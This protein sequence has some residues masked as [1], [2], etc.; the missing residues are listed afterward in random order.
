MRA[1]G[2]ILA[3]LAVASCNA[4]RDRPGIIVLP[5]MAFTVPYDTYDANPVTGQTLLV[6]PEGT[7]PYGFQPFGYEPGPEEAAR[8]G[9]ELVNPLVGIEA[10]IFAAELA[11]G[12]KVY[13]IFCL[14][15]HGPGGDG[16][17]PIIGRFPNPPS[18]LAGP[19]RR[20]PD[21]EI[22]HRIVH[23]QALMPGYAVQVQPED[24]WRL[25]SYVRALQA[26]ALAEA[27]APVEPA[28]ETP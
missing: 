20:M 14:V 10:E 1:L 5:G 19:T 23:G 22:Y 16:D 6:P 13:A 7:V 9:R 3:L 26:A 2:T 15:C 21:G 18:L 27:D 11:R 28:G 24:R 4:Q 17:G 25:V 8:A 12:K